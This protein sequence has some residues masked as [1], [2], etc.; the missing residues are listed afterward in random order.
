ME[1]IKIPVLIMF[2]CNSTFAFK[3]FFILE[4]E[5]VTFSANVCFELTISL[6]F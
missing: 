6:L 1:H 3:M 2:Y 4:A 5:N